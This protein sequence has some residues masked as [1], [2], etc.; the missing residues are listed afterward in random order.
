MSTIKKTETET[1][2][3]VWNCEKPQVVESFGT[4]GCQCLSQKQEG[5][6]W[7]V[8]LGPNGKAFGKEK[9]SD[10]FMSSDLEKET[11]FVHDSTS[12]SAI[13]ALCVALFGEEGL[14]LTESL[15]HA[16]LGAAGWQFAGQ[17]TQWP[18]YASVRSFMEEY[19]L[20]L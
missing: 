20:A 2:V 5:V 18:E 16:Y 10:R 3:L 15:S 8:Y 6:S 9:V 4:E 11:T 12:E 14:I 19:L 7:T 13:D 17:S 1:G